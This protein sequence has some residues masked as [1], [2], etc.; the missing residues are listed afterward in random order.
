MRYHADFPVR[1]RHCRGQADRALN[2]GGMR[3]DISDITRVMMRDA[4]FISETAIEDGI[5]DFVAWYR[6]SRK[7]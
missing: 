3:R 1:Q 2:H 4:S 6:D 7:V 5:R